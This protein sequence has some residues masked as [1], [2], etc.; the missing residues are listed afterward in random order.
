MK[1]LKTYEDLTGILFTIALGWTL[2]KFLD[3]LSADIKRR[4]RGKKNDDISNKNLSFL[5]NKLKNMKDIP[6]TNLNDRFFIRI[7]DDLDL[8]LF[9]ETKILNIETPVGEQKIQLSD[10]EFDT[11]LKLIKRYDK[12]ENLKTFERFEQLYTFECSGSPKPTFKTKADFFEYME[13]HG[14]KHTTLTKKT[15]MLILQ[16]K[17]QGTLKEEKAKRYGIPI[18]TYAEA[19]KRVKEMAKDVAT[20][21]L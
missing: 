11:F 10:S 9:K 12:M 4:K 3:G 2:W 7:G 1:H 13:E 8:R 16:Y 18:Y 15:D 17:G 14:F 19:K 21:N 5:F 6:V 20:Y